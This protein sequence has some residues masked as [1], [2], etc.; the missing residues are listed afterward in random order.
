MSG[1]G[2][3]RKGAAAE[4]E[5]FDILN[6]LLGWKA[7]KRNLVQSR[8][9]GADSE[10]NDALPCAIEVK[11]QETW[12]LGVWLKQ[13]EEQA[14]KLGKYPVLAFRSNQEPWRVLVEMTP[15]QFANWV[16]LMGAPPGGKYKGDH[17]QQDRTSADRKDDDGSATPH[18]DS[19]RGADGGQ[20]QDSVHE[21]ATGTSRHGTPGAPED[22]RQGPGSGHG[23]ALGQGLSLAQTVAR[24]WDVAA[25]IISQDHASDYI[26]S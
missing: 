20:R 1:A 7:F 3:R 4:R 23:T 17:A 14:A 22:K 2:S 9:G 5:L 10:D 21:G 12:S 19:G 25:D 24:T 15:E 13:A 11:R 16:Y 8:V 18:R 6:Q 26:G